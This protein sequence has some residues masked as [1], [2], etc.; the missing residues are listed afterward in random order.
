VENQNL[1]LILSTVSLTISGITA[2]L[3]LFRRGTVEMTQPTVIFFGPDG[4]DGPPKIFLRTLLFSTAKRG[5]VLENMYIKLHRGESTQT[6][7]IWVYGDQS[8]VRGSGLHVGEEGAS[9]NH[10]FLLPKDGTRY[11]FLPGEYTIE[12]FASLVN[13]HR[14]SMLHK[15]TLTLTQE[16]ATAIKD[17]HAGVYFDW[18]PD[19]MTY[20]SHVDE[21]PTPRLR[22]LS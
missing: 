11:E 20:Q 8:I 1:S 22:R 16:Q 21:H 13:R 4:D 3:T 10:H 7:N 12:I 2:W 17:K 14:P 19:S 6:F 5:Q 18:G 9:Y 15:V